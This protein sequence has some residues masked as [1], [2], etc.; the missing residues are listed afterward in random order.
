MLCKAYEQP[1]S[2]NNVITCSFGRTALANADPPA[3]EL[4]QRIRSWDVT[5]TRLKTDGIVTELPTK[6][7][8]MKYTQGFVDRANP[9]GNLQVGLM[10]E[11]VTRT[12][13]LVR[14]FSLF[15]KE[16]RGVSHFLSAVDDLPRLCTKTPVA[17]V[18]LDDRN[19]SRHGR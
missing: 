14:V 19:D 16:K 1:T 3:E 17:S 18:A 6:R 13:C 11:N 2:E 5:M 15:G 7:L 10:C 8:L 4:V 12:N 9:P